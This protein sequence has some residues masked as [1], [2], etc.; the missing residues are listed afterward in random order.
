MFLDTVLP[1]PV[2][3]EFADRPGGEAS[4]TDLSPLPLGEGEGEG[5]PLGRPSAVLERKE[6]SWRILSMGRVK[7][8]SMAW[9]CV[10]KDGRKKD[11][12]CGR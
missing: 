10:K 5:L 7:L 2:S 8:T 6:T 1:P 3:C 4:V 9:S 12:S 11:F